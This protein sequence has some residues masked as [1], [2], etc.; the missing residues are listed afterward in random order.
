V[1]AITT[2]QLL[3][4]CDNL[5]QLEGEWRL[6]T[7][8]GAR[9]QGSTHSVHAA[10]QMCPLSRWRAIASAAAKARSRDG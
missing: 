7:G 4:T 2:T 9:F 10:V 6:E 3:T 1:L 5:P 8:R